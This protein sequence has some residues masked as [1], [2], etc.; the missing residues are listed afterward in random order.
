MSDAVEHPNYYLMPTGAETIDISQW[1]TS[2]GGQAVQYI[3]RATRTDGVVKENPIEDV[4]KAI[5][6]MNVERKRLAF[7]Q[8]GGGAPDST[9]SPDVEELYRRALASSGEV[10]LEDDDDTERPLNLV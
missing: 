10:G 2:A 5:F 6:W 9:D 1:L 3:V 4:D 7:L 8:G